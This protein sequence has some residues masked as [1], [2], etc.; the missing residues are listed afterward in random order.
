MLKIVKNK[1]SKAGINIELRP[2]V[3]L[4]TILMKMTV[5]EKQKFGLLVLIFIVISYLSFYLLKHNTAESEVIEINFADRFTAAHKILI[6]KYNAKHRGKIRVV[7]VDFPNLDFSTNERKEILA[8]S[9]RGR[10]D[11]IDLFA[12]D[13]IWVQRFAK[14]SE[15]VDK[16]F[17]P[18]EKDRILSNALK[19][20]YFEGELVAV[21][22]DLVQGVIYYREDLIKKQ[23]NADQILSKLMNGISWPEFIK[24]KDKIA[25]NNPYYV[26]PAADYEGLICSYMEIILSQDPEYFNKYGFNFE[27]PAAKKALQL[28]VDLVGKDKLTPKVVSGFTE[29]PS[30]AYFIEKDGLFIRGWPSYDKDFKQVPYDRRKEAQL[31]KMAIPRYEGGVP[32]SI[33]G[34]WNLM[35]SKFSDKKPAVIDFVKYLLSDEAQEILYRESGYYPVI[36]KL[37]DDLKY[38][39][40]YPEIAGIKQMLQ[41]GMH[42]PAHVEY[43]RFSKIMSFYFSR[44]ISGEMSVD[45][46]LSKCTAAIQYDNEMINDF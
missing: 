25:L 40:K 8:R 18:A 29:V 24:L 14:W 36:K 33:L 43:T 11:G 20:C 3:I 39:R 42:R 4:K 34:G 31:K 45:D 2:A 32:V 26:F 22:F 27:K 38:Q 10:G 5:T 46:A 44:A 15:P 7:P 9:L 30:Y 19:S 41:I 16:Y 12:V 37:Y 13:L 35:I 28:L 1:L 6:E 21:P 17:T 23:K